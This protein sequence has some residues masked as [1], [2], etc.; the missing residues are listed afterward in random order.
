MEILLVED[1]PG[2]VR[3]TQETLKEGTLCINMNVV[4]D[5]IEADG[6]P[7]PR[8]RASAMRHGPT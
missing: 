8:G 6:V 5:G 7:A 4:T 2:D 1:N 3:L